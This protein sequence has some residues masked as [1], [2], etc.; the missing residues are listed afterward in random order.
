MS[1]THTRRE[2]TLLFIPIAIVFSKTS[3][4]SHIEYF[5][6]LK[7]WQPTCFMATVSL[8]LFVALYVLRQVRYLRQIS[9]IIKRIIY[10]LGEVIQGVSWVG[11]L[12]LCC[13]Q[14]GYLFDLVPDLLHVTLNLGICFL[15]FLSFVG[16]VEQYFGG[17]PGPSHVFLDLRSS[18]ISFIITRSLMMG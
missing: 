13:H 16:L 17:T 4:I 18:M 15:S 3:G 14:V 1:D 6:S 7:P 9:S 2:I 11:W 8:S 5:F 10:F 12:H